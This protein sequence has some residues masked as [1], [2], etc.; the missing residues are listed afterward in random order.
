[1]RLRHLFIALL[2]IGSAG[3]TSSVDLTFDRVPRSMVYIPFTTAGQWEI[4]GA[5]GPM[6]HTRFIRTDTES[7]PSNYTYPDYSYTGY[8]GIL[9]LCDIHSTLRAYDLSCPVERQ[10][11]VRVFV[12]TETN[13]AECPQCHSTYDVFLLNGALPGSPTGGPALTS[14]YGMRS[15]QVLFGV[16][17]RYALISN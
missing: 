14:G 11:N 17:G 8:G 10:R 16:D 4:Y 5:I 7:L 1:M 13:M 6:T 9:Q 12:N 2:A 3:C 15:Y